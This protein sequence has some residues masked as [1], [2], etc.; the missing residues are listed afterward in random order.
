MALHGTVKQ[1]REKTCRN[2]CTTIIAQRAQTLHIASQAYD[3]KC[4]HV[5]IDEADILVHR[6]QLR[7]WLR[8]V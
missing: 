1:M 3:G 6:Q 5:V 8:A 4:I 2:E 7:A